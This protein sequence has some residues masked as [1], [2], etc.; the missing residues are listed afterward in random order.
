[1]EVGN[2]SH[3]TTG[4][5]N[6]LVSIFVLALVTACSETP[7]QQSNT[8]QPPVQT[9]STSDL[10]KRGPAEAS[11]TNVL[12]DAAQPKSK[13]E[14]A[15]H[16]VANTAAGEP[17]S[18]MASDPT[19][20]MSNETAIADLGNQ[21]DT[22]R[23]PGPAFVVNGDAGGIYWEP[24][25]QAAD[26]NRN[27]NSYAYLELTLSSPTGK[28][29]NHRFAPGEP[30]GLSAASG[31]LPD[32]AYKWETVTAPAIAPEVRTEMAAVRES[33]DIAA[34]QALKQKLRSE[35][36]MPTEVQARANRQFGTFTVR[37]GEIIPGDVGQVARFD[38]PE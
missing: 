8:G 5:H 37:N 25:P 10:S 20:S 32:G 38:N 4:A 6:A 24:N 7:Q 31:T 2:L 34:E 35:G 16:A 29:I 19:Q 15:D 33:G 11:A 23:S 36:Q 13:T 21:Q 9:A 28:I 18:D 14:V 1:M 17:A 26:L 22:R 12:P 30:V 27:L 3:T